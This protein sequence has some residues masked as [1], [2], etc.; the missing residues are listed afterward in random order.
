MTNSAWNMRTMRRRCQSRGS[1]VRPDARR[2]TPTI[3]SHQAMISCTL[4]VDQI[5]QSINIRLDLLP[6][7]IT[8]HI[9]AIIN[10]V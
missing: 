8:L 10:L 7:N 2:Q 5:T 3:K 4:V 6:N 9:H 1:G